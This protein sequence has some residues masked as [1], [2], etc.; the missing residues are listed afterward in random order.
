M[1]EETIVELKDTKEIDL[2]QIDLNEYTGKKVKINEVTEHEGVHGYYVKIRTE[3]VGKIT[4]QKGEE[5]DLRASKLLGLQKDKEEN[6]GWGATTKM[7][8]YLKRMAVSHY[9][10]LVGKEVTVIALTNDKKEKDFLSFN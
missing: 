6:V 4:N 5:K 1:A 8:L 2:P 7:G 3:A 9:S 10:E